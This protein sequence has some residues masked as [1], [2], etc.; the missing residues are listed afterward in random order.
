MSIQ[1]IRAF[2]KRELKYSYRRISHVSAAMN[3]DANKRKRRAAAID[4]FNSLYQGKHII[5]IDETLLN[6]TDNRVYSW[7]LKKAYRN[8]DTPCSIIN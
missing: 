7:C 3:S 4:Y 6:V 1:Q 2:L 8:L 5:N